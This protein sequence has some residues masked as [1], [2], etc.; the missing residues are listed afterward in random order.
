MLSKKELLKRIIGKK[1]QIRHWGIFTIEKLPPETDDSYY[2]I[3]EVG[4]E[5]FVAI[6][7]HSRKQ[8]KSFYT[9]DHVSVISDDL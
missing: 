9:I 7:Y 2:I 5:M 3:T 6:W 4:D 1:V 8:R